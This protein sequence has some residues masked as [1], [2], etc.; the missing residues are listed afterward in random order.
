MR[1]P[2]QAVG[3]LWL[4]FTAAR[5]LSLDDDMG[6]DDED[7]NN[8]YNNDTRDGDCDDGMEGRGQQ[9]HQQRR[10]PPPDDDIVIAWPPTTLT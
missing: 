8:K 7:C 2:R 9:R 6:S 10:H 3:G 1:L 5:I 4:D